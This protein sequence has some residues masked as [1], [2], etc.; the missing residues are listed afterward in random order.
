MVPDSKSIHIV[1]EL[2]SSLSV[3]IYYPSTGITF[4]ERETMHTAELRIFHPCKDQKVTLICIHL[5]RLPY[6]RS[7]QDARKGLA[8]LHVC[9]HCVMK[10]ALLWLIEEWPEL[11]LISQMTFR[12]DWITGESY[13]I[14]RPQSPLENALILLPQHAYRCCRLNLGHTRPT[15]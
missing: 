9:P 10:M 11:S 12:E 5:P 8:L 3:A 6:R 13:A 14:S 7:T 1:S 15:G 4:T 2:N